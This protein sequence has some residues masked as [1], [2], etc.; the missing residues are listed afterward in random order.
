MKYFEN[1]TT[2]EDLKTEYKRLAKLHHPDKGGSTEIMQEINR[3]YTAFLKSN[4]DYMAMSEREKEYEEKLPEIINSLIHLEGLEIEI[5]YLW[6]WV[7]GNTQPHK[8]TLKELGLKWAYKKKKWYY[9]KEEHAV[10]N[11]TNMTYEQITAKYGSK[12]VQVKPAKVIEC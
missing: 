8:E 4:M 7:S 2:L 11:R 9:R 6:V 5:V 1:I 10:R 3:L 12:K